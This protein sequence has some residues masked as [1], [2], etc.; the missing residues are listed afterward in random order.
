MADTRVEAYSHYDEVA[1]Q[2]IESI[3]ARLSPIERAIMQTP[4]MSHYWEAPID[5]IDWDARAV[6][7]LIEAV[8]DF[9]HTPLPFRN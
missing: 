2:Q 6:R 7:L 8:C 1:T 3:L 5:R 4:V 9:A